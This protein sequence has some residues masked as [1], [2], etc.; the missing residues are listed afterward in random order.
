MKE[1]VVQYI[2]KGYTWKEKHG[3]NKIAIIRYPGI[4]GSYIIDFLV[5]DCLSSSFSNVERV[6]MFVYVCCRR[7]GVGAIHILLHLA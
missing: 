1:Y 4:V 2:S 6:R 5:Y 3:S 7:N